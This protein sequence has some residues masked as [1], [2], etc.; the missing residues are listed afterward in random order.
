MMMMD[1][2]MYGTYAKQ[3]TYHANYNLSSHGTS[4]GLSLS[5][6]VVEQGSSSPELGLVPGNSGSHYYPHGAVAPYSTTSASSSTAEVVYL[7]HQQQ[8][9]QHQQSSGTESSAVDSSA[10]PPPALQAFYSPSGA[11]LHEDTPPIISSE[12]GLS[13]TNLDYANSPPSYVPGISVVQQPNLHHSHQH[14][15]HHHQH[16]NTPHGSAMGYHHIQHAGPPSNASYCSRD[17]SLHSPGPPHSLPIASGTTIH[18]SQHQQLGQGAQ[19]ASGLAI[20]QDHERLHS[21]QQSSQTQHH[22]HLSHPHSHHQPRQNREPPEYQSPTSLLPSSTTNYLHQHHLTSVPGPTTEDSMQYAAGTSMRLQTGY[23]HPSADYKDHEI[24]AYHALHQTP[25]HSLHG[26]RI[27]PSQ[28]G[29]SLHPHHLHQSQQQQ[30]QQQQQQHGI[31]ASASILGTAQHQAGH[32]HPHQQQQHQQPQAQVPTY[33][34]MQVKRNVPKPVGAKSTQNGGD[35]GSNVGAGS[36]LSI[37]LVSG[38]VTTVYSPPGTS[39]VASGSGN[40]LGPDGSPVN[41]LA[42]SQSS[43]GSLGL[44][45]SSMSSL[46]TGAFNNTGRT[47]FTNK[48]LTELEKEF[49]FN[50]Y[51]TRARRIEIASALQLNETQVKI[52]FQNRRMKQKKRLKEGL[53]GSSGGEVASGGTASTTSGTV[54]GGLLPNN[55]SAHLGNIC[56]S[57]SSSPTGSTSHLEIGSLQSGGMSF[58]SDSNCHDSPPAVANNKE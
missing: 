37:G 31:A 11:L 45:T 23:G 41:C 56:R 47:N 39:N 32:H 28:H 52:W 8:Q 46:S 2:G 17:D 44:S 58:A 6:G 19:Q 15:A 33:K 40:A 20:A 4:V 26:Q 49:H 51:L 21:L 38:A 55:G 54:S 12:N 18:S 5:H 53:I 16:A 43:A 29:L 34:W 22:Q 14:H 10:T 27:H 25:T 30:Q 36:G 42:G 1:M 7:Q 57:T 9:Q 48:Q 50:K 3:D 24:A 35:F 13:Y